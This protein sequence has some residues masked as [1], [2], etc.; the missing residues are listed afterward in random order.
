MYIVIKT[1]PKES[2]RISTRIFS[3]M[4]GGRL[5]HMYSLTVPNWFHRVHRV[6]H[7]IQV[8]KSRKKGD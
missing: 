2:L 5:H 3:A 1:L 6:D 4:E 8:E 7:G